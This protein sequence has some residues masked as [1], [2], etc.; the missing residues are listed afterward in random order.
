MNDTQRPAES[1]KGLDDVR[2][3]TMD[4]LCDAG[5]FSETEGMGDDQTGVRKKA[6][7]PVRAIGED[8]DGYD[9]YSDYMQGSREPG[10]ERDPWS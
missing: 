8:D 9:P 6:G 1:D 10:F 7:Q 3:Q 2:D 4:G 5:S